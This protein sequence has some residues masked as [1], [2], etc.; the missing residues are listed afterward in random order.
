MNDFFKKLQEGINKNVKGTH[1]SLM[2]ESNIVTN[3]YM[4]KTPAYDLNRI[5]SGS[6]KSGIQ[7]RNLVGIVGPEH[8]GKSSFMILCMAEAIRQGKKAVIIDTEG[9][10]NKEFCLRWGLDIDNVF[11]VYTPFVSE[12]RSV[13]GQIRETG[14]TDLI[15][16]IDSA[17]GL[18][19]LKQFEDAASGQM[20]ADQGLLQKE[21]RSMLKLYLNICIAQNSIGIITGHM[22][23]S[24]GTVPMPDKI[25]GGKAMKLFP[26]IL[27][28]LY[29]YSIYENPNDKK[30]PIIGT[31]IKATTL[32]NRMYPP[33]QT[34]TVHLDYH[35]GIES[36]AG[37]L[38]LG[39]K[40]DIIKQNG[41]WY[42][43][44]DERLGQGKINAIS[45]LYRFGGFLDKL[46]EWLENTGYSSYNKEVEEAEKLI[47]VELKEEI[48]EPK[49]IRGKE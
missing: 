2:S 11:Y 5:L 32:K 43:I 45:N 31:E 17:G 7:S 3:R 29:K 30:S 23:G 6:V 20:K 35:N 16:G 14:D 25:G 21:I 44:G 18:D 9:G 36:Y 26:S 49:K 33:F 4:I 10:V 48:E 28:Q 12:V 42:S 41:S 40:A 8:A 27:I 46:D 24:P 19:R 34:A 22:Y 15:I 1:A 37:L 13:L 47:E 39:I 38:E